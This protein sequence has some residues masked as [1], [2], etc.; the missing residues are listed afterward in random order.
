MNNFCGKC[1]ASLTD[2]S[3]EAK[4]CPKCG[5]AF[6]APAV[7]TQLPV[8]DL[9]DLPSRLQYVIAMVCLA[10]S[11]GAM[12]LLNSML[13]GDEQPSVAIALVNAAALMW[14]CVVI[15]KIL[16]VKRK[17]IALWAVR[18]FYVISTATVFSL[19]FFF[20]I[21]QECKNMEDLLSLIQILNTVGI[22]L[23]VVYAAVLAALGFALTDLKDHAAG[24]RWFAGIG[25]ALILCAI[26]SLISDIY[27]SANFEEMI[28]NDEPD[29]WWSAVA[30]ESI[31]LFVLF[32]VGYVFMPGDDSRKTECGSKTAFDG[33]KFGGISI[34]ILMIGWRSLARIHRHSR[35]HM[36]EHS[37][38]T[39]IWVVIILGLILLYLSCRFISYSKT[40]PADTAEYGNAEVSKMLDEDSKSEMKV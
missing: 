40:P 23:S 29:S 11:I 15:K 34:V 39:F 10:V 19:I 13:D 37:G 17:M 18:L 38:D 33:F 9:S 31:V 8:Y 3:A 2:V 36:Y 4:F 7:P 25:V 21:S 20:N 35:S 14:P 27:Y 28:M 16:S 32:I 30:L 22:C 5:A 6:S 24:R 26:L 12:I 1:G